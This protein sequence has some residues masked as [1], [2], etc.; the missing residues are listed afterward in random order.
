MHADSEH[1]LPRA[2]PVPTQPPWPPAAATMPP[3]PPPLPYAQPL[4]HDADPLLLMSQTRA[5]ALGDV[6]L[7]HFIFVAMLIAPGFVF[8]MLGLQTL[9]ENSPGLGMAVTL[10]VGFAT[11][12]IALLI[13]RLRNQPLAALGIH[14]RDMA[15]NI[16]VGVAAGFVILLSIFAFRV[17]LAMVSKSIRNAMFQS[18]KDTGDTIPEMSFL[19][20][21]VVA[22]GVGLY[23]ELLFRGFA[24]PRLRRLT[25]SWVAAT[26]IGS[27]LFALLHGYQG[28]VGMVTV[29]FLSVGLSIT[30][31][32]RK[33]IVPVIVAHFL[34]DAIGFTMLHLV[35]PEDLKLPETTAWILCG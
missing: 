9:L 19:L 34:I 13:A 5:S 23:E 12:G 31:V 32:L 29:F 15:I 10:G 1:P 25:G 6:I 21:L 20:T 2:R 18:A 27:I 33:S 8:A 14:G 4:A 35:N 17:F 30:F 3:A 26:I 28:F 16:G 11:V 24:L 7:I 22:A